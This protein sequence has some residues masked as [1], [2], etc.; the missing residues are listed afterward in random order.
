[1][2]LL[3]EHFVPFVVKN[4]FQ[5][6]AQHHSHISLTTPPQLR[7][8]L[9]NR[10]ARLGGPIRRGSRTILDRLRNHRLGDGIGSLGTVQRD[11]A[12]DPGRVQRRV[13][14][15]LRSQTIADHGA[16]WLRNSYHDFLSHLYVRHPRV[17]APAR[18]GNSLRLD[19]RDKSLGGAIHTGGIGAARRCHE[20]RRA[21]HGRIQYR[22]HRRPIPW[23][24][25]DTLDRR[26]RL[27]RRLSGDP[28]SIGHGHAVHP[29][30]QGG[31]GRPGTQ[32]SGASSKKA[33][34][35]FG[36]RR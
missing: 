19:P 28:S 36:I 31:I 30:P 12:L 27:L 18:A 15:P 11:T 16:I 8:L 20:R 1:M 6:G 23:R 10:S 25:V 5:Q 29:Q 3:F 2:L 21:L 9:V 14:G 13:G 7:A 4:I 24:R 33:F 22:A 17:L 34:T 35:M 32:F 26:R